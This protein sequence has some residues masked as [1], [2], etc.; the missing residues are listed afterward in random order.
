MARRK[1]K[2]DPVQALRTVRYSIDNLDMKI[3]NLLAQ[4]HECV[5]YA[6]QL[7]QI[8]AEEQGENFAVAARSPDRVKEVIHNVR[9]RAEA[10]GLDPDM[11]ECLYQMLIKNEVQRE[12]NE[13][14]KKK[15]Q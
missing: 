2:L 14:Y 11:L 7:K 5:T 15:K 3:V 13:V 10:R 8:I 4:R 12:L 6:A 9:S 1:E